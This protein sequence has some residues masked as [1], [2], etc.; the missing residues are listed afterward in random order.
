MS[1]YSKLIRQLMY[2]RKIKKNQ[3]RLYKRISLKQDKVDNEIIKMRFGTVWGVEDRKVNFDGG[4]TPDH[5]KDALRP[6]VAL[7]HANEQSE[8]I[9]IAPGTSKIHSNTNSE[10]IL[11][12][13]VPPENL[14][15]TTYFLLHYNQSVFKDDLETKF[16]ELS[17]NLQK[18]LKNLLERNNGEE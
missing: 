14:S 16:A 13:K 9:E 10:I 11:T 3:I 7:E 18:K 6:C 4:R 2:V 17:Q 1:D 12:A 5:F 8:I 15:K